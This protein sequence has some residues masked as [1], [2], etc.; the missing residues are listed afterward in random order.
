MNSN[1]REFLKGAAGTSLA[2]LAAA[3]VSAGATTV[4]TELPTGAEI[5]QRR[6]RSLASPEMPRGMTLLSIR[7]EHGD[8]LGVKTDRGILDVRRASIALHR[9]VPLTLDV[10][11][12]DGGASELTRLI[13]AARK[14]RHA[15][16]LYLDEA[17]ITHGRLFAEPGKI[18]CIGL[19]YREHAAEAGEK[20]PAVPI[21]FNK[22]N[23]SLTSH[24]ATIRLPTDVA[25]KFDYEVEMLVV[26]GRRAHNVSLE[27]AA[28]YIA[29]YCTANDF[30]ARDLQLELDGHQWMIGKTLDDFAPIGP[31]FVTADLVEDPN[32]LN[33]ECRVNGETRQHSNT[34]RLV[35]NTEFLVSYISRHFPL[36]PG[37]LIFTGTP[38]G[39]I[40][41][42][43]KEKQVWLKAGDQVACSVGSL[44]ELRFTLA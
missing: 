44:G 35:Y 27:D 41:G 10:L 20:V 31:Y 34:N 4:S 9:P 11:L 25:T 40:L 29:G 38:P 22:F 14:S 37:D 7:S 5:V 6:K 39:V 1:R 18:V 28:K 12:Q 23:N 24:G 13:D 8:T 2:G 19:N 43:P 3:A 36:E 21:L 15:D 30:S 42:M 33:I 32:K 16:A 17:A 26:I